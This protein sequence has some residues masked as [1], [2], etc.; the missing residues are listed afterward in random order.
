M[1]KLFL[2]ERAHPLGEIFNR[3][4][5]LQIALIAMSV[6]IGI[7]CSAWVIKGTLLKTALEQEMAHYWQRV[8]INPQA[9]LPDTKN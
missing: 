3:F 2:N 4:Y 9:E 8:E 7:S 5:W 6:V 1:L